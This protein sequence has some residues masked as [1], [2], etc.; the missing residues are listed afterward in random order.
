MF[1]SRY[2]RSR[3]RIVTVPFY[4]PVRSEP[5]TFCHGGQLLRKVLPPFR[6]VI[7]YARPGVVVTHSWYCHGLT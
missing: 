4:N 3:R 2:P 5:V 1:V 6:A 7:K